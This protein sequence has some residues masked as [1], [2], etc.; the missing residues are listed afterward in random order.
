MSMRVTFLKG[1]DSPN[2]ENVELGLPSN[3]IDKHSQE[4]V[5]EVKKI[6][7][8][9][10][11]NSLSTPKLLSGKWWEDGHDLETLSGLGDFSDGLK[12]DIEDLDPTTGL[13][14][15]TTQSVAL[16]LAPSE[17]IKPIQQYVGAAYS[18]SY[19]LLQRRLPSRYPPSSTTRHKPAAQYAIK[20]RKSGTHT[21]HFAEINVAQ[22][23]YLTRKISR[24]A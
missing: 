7:Q 6:T 17:D 4:D 2:P 1:R 12:D 22:V 11:V 24:V 10:I 16:F 18:F 19:V 9:Y 23:D 14:A 8:N 20:F 13:G 15:Q 3:E 21:W 5:T